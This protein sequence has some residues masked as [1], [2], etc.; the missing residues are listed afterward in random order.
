MTTESRCVREIRW[1][2]AGTVV[3]LQG[4]VDLHHSPEVHRALVTTC[5]RKPAR[6]VVDL[7]QVSY[8][9]SSGIGILVEVYR[10]V[11]A[12]GGA[13]MVCGLADRVRS[14]FEITKLDKFFH[15]CETVEEALSA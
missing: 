4:E 3:V 15:M 2:N 13:L 14:V 5:E 1:E 12:Y 9:D 11:R 10:R 8:M 6:L 7:T